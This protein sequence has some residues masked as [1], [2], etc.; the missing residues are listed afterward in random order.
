MRVAAHWRVGDVSLSCGLARTGL[1]GDAAI[2]TLPQVMFGPHTIS[3]LIIGGNPFKGFSH[4]TPGM[5]QEMRDYYTEEQMVDVLLR[6]QNEGMTAMQCRA[7]HHIM[8]MI[9]AYRRAGGTMQWIAQTAS[10]WEDV[11]DN[12]R[13]MA[14]LEPIAVYHHGSRTDSYFQQGRMDVVLERIEM[15]GR[16]GIMAGVGAHLPE[17]FEWVEQQ[18]WPVDFYMCS[19]YNLSK[20]A[21]TEPAV[22]GH[23]PEDHLFA[24]PDRDVVF[25]FVRRTDKPCLV[26]KVLAANRKC[27]SQDDVRE[28]YRYALDRIKPDDAVVVGMFPKHQDQ[29]RL[30]AEH[31]RA[32]CE[33]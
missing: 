12:I 26:F 33:A 29:V 1:T 3:R 16:L 15:I 28:A 24:D 5:D 25:D 4:Y 8:S 18:D 11:L 6:C 9:R 10:E 20:E 31:V 27:G 30:N 14:E 13:V 19:V 22:A 2:A 17:A 7:D 23:R 32:L 21:K